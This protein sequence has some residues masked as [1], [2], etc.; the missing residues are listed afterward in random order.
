M[1]CTSDELDHNL[2]VFDIEEV[3]ER[4]RDEVVM[5]VSF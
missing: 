2:V 3:Q 1:E 5:G 4:F